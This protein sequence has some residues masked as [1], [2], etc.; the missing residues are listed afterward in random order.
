MKI[1][2]NSII[3]PDGTILTSRGPNPISLVDLNGNTYTISGGLS[4]IIRDCPFPDYKENSV[5]FNDFFEKIR[6]SLEIPISPGELILLCNL[7][8]IYLATL[9]NIVLNSDTQTELDIFYL[10]EKKYR[11]AN[12]I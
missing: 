11:E 9:C 5:Y 7:S 10:K 1:I 2:K 8:N 6:T 12:E 4:S 3:T